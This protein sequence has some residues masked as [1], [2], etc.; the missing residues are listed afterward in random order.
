MGM[1]IN[2]SGGEG[3][4]TDEAGTAGVGADTARR[5]GS[6]ALRLETPVLRYIDVPAGHSQTHAVVVATAGDE[7]IDLEVVTPPLAPFSVVER[8]GMERTDP[9]AEGTTARIW[10]RYDANSPMAADSGRVT[11]ADRTTGLQWTVALDGRGSLAEAEEDGR[12]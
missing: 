10:I 8:L 1:A 2:N 11:V 9:A 5:T 7:P 6:N 12:T 4:T 3:H